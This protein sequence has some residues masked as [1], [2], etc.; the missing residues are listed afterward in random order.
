MFRELLVGLAPQFSLPSW[1]SSPHI[2]Q[3]NARLKAIV[4]FVGACFGE[5]IR[6][7]GTGQGWSRPVITL[8]AGVELSNSDEEACTKLAALEE[9][10]ESV[11]GGVKEALDVGKNALTK[12]SES[13]TPRAGGTKK[14]NL[15][16]FRRDQYYVSHFDDSVSLYSN[17]DMLARP[18]Y[19][20][21]RGYTHYPTPN[22]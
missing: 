2:K 22:L 17:K 10:L 18:D 21:F 7:M 16:I 15:R 4:C 11:E 14:S 12:A 5:G 8:E 3:L 13:T 19:A 6:R 9:R 20:L 1:S